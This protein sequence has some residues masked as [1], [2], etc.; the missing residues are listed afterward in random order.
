MWTYSTVNAKIGTAS[1]V[2]YVSER[3]RPWPQHLLLLGRSMVSASRFV[4]FE[5]DES[6]DMRVVVRASLS[7]R[8]RSRSTRFWTL[9]TRPHRRFDVRI[10]MV[11]CSLD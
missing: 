8:V 6:F 1:R 4:S 9:S 5:Y 11:T 2:L 7:R 3:N 10:G